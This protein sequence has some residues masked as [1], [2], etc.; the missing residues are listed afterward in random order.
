MKHLLRHPVL[1]GICLEVLLTASGKYFSM[2]DHKRPDI[3]STVERIHYPANTFIVGMADLLGLEIL[4]V[5]L[6]VLSST[7]TAPVWIVL[8]YVVGGFVDPR[9]GGVPRKVSRQVRREAEEEP[10][11][12]QEKPQSDPSLVPRKA[13]NNRTG[14][15]DTDD[16]TRFR[17]L[18]S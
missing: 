17:W 12:L 9:L 16:R 15:S 18:H 11:I 2:P 14:P 3:V 6:M 8:L 10:G 1:V 5:Q 4:P 7:F 13:G